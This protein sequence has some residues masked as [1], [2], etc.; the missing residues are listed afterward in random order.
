MSS[1][2]LSVSSGWQ[3][4]SFGRVCS[5]KGVITQGYLHPSGYR[6][7]GILGKK[8]PVHRVIMI[9][10]HGLPPNQEAWQVNHIDGQKANNR[11]ENLEYASQSQNINHSVTTLQRRSAGP[12]TS[13]QVL[14]RV[15]GAKTW[16]MFSSVRLA[17]QQLG[18]S[19]SAVSKHCRNLSSARG[20]EFRFPALHET[21]WCGEE[22]KS[23][24]DPVSGVEVFGRMVS[25]FG[26]ITSV[27]GVTSRGCLTKVGYYQTLL[28]VNGVTRGV[29]VHRLV[30]M[31]FLGPSPSLQQSVVN[32]KDLDKS[33]NH[34]DNLEWATQSENQLHFLAKS[35]KKARSDVKSVWSRVYGDCGEWML[36][37]SMTSAEA[38]LG[39]PRSSISRCV[40]GLAKQ[41]AGYE[42]CSAE[43]HEKSLQVGE[44]WRDVDVSA[45][46]R[47]RNA[48]NH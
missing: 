9:S 21:T 46:L 45:L 15:L 33:N 18:M 28:R 27:R 25:S 17:A 2:P 1:Q 47:D 5:P 7:V 41:A 14:W 8:W 20:I 30:A 43:P 22:W 42:F 11:L 48:R 39:V 10:F 29:L 40:R 6:I 19:E 34:V 13:K 35:Q 24:L 12:G 38:A 31:A 32:H 23:M 26:R 36:H 3:V 37:R 16:D 4:S 44:E